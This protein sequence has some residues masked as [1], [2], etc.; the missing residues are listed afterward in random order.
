MTSMDNHN[1]N[2][3]N[4]MTATGRNGHKLPTE[5]N[6]EQPSHQAAA[7]PPTERNSNMETKI[8]QMQLRQSNN[9]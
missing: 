8:L 3:T 5:R 9:R 4:S 7:A 1:N 2:K 6:I